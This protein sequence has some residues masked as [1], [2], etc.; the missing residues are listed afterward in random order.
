MNRITTGLSALLLVVSSL[1]A[2]AQPRGAQVCGGDYVCTGDPSVVATWPLD[3]WTSVRR[4]QATSAVAPAAKRTSRLA[5]AV[6][7]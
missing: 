6:N 2:A 4:Q 1:P 5:R 3:R 7:R